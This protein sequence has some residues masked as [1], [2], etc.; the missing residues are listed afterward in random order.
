M[1]WTAK[2]VSE[3]RWPSAF[4]RHAADLGTRGF[5]L[6][7][8]SRPNGVFATVG[9]RMRV[10]VEPERAEDGSEFAAIWLAAATAPE[11]ET[12]WL[13]LLAGEALARRK[14]LNCA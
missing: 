1:R 4:R 5:A 6:V 2:S 9:E 14:S 7:V 8:W 3:V 11:V 13:G 10:G 12:F